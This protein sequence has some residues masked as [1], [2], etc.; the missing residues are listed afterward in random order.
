[1]DKLG[2][3][4]DKEYIDKI[5]WKN[6]DR[7]NLSQ[8]LKDLQSGDVV[9][10]ESISRLGRNVDDLRALCRALTD[11]GII[12]YFIKEGFNTGGSTY[13]FL[14]TILGGV[15]EMERELIQ[16]RVTQRIS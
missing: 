6:V 2:I 3:K 15:A 16:E 11:R 7:P 14:L 4:F 9:Y 10:C 8:M 13:E 5:S 1:M 12:V